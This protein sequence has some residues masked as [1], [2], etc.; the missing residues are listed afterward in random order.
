[1]KKLFVLTIVILLSMSLIACSS[2][3]S[4]PQKESQP[5]STQGTTEIPF[6][7]EEVTLEE[8]TPSE[9]TIPSEETMPIEETIPSEETEASVTG[10]RPDFKQ[11]MDEY[12]AFYDEYCE[13]MKKYKENPTDLSLLSQYTA[14]MTEAIE[15]SEAFEAW[16]QEEM[17]SEELKYYLEVNNRV[18]QK[19]ADLLD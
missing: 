19:M 7:S 6:A 2:T 17:T 10:I 18:L 15:M 12:E 11:A 16:D 9:S 14:F 5:A 13:L 1:M 3:S 4:N 8:T